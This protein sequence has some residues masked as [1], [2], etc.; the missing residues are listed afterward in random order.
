MDRA[1]AAPWDPERWLAAILAGG[2]ILAGMRR[3]SIPSLLMLAGG[4]ALAWWA[5]SDIDVRNR[6]RGQLAAVWPSQW[7]SDDKVVGDASEASFPASDAP[8]W[9]PTTGHTAGPSKPPAKAPGPW[10]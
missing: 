8:S 10:H 9:T 6:R 5:A 1:G 7:Y 3:R 2:L 4:S